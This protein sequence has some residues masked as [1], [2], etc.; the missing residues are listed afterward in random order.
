MLNFILRRTTAC[1]NKRA[2]ISSI[3]CFTLRLLL[4]TPRG[5]EPSGEKV[6]RLIQIRLTRRVLKKSRQPVKPIRRK[7]GLLIRV[8]QKVVSMSSARTTNRF[9]SPRC[10]LAI[11][12][13]RP[14]ES[15]AETQS[16][17]QPVLGIVDHLRRGFG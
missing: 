13:V 15:I 1:H 11:Q 9:P 2:I 16:Q 5:E 12:I 8:P 7:V 14:L 6:L 4:F 17:L 3:I 10:A